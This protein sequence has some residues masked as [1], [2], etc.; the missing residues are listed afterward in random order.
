[1]KAAIETGLSRFSARSFSRFRKSR[2]ALRPLGVLVKKRYDSGMLERQAGL[3]HVADG[4]RRHFVDA[5]AS[6]RPGACEDDLPQQ[7]RLLQRDRLRDET[8]KGEA[9]QVDLVEAQGLDEG[10]RIPR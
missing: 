5:R 10:Y 1:M 9:K 7:L 6:G 3:D 2:A 8:A 4:H